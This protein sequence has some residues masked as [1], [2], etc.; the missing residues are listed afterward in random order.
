M[1]A[2]FGRLLLKS[3]LLKYIFCSVSQW[4][5]TS[6]L[7]TRLG[8]RCTITHLFRILCFLSISLALS[9]SSLY[10]AF[11]GHTHSFFGAAWSREPSNQLGFSLQCQGMYAFNDLLR[12]CM[13]HSKSN[14]H[15]LIRTFFWTC[16]RPASIDS[17][18]NRRSMP[19]SGILRTCWTLS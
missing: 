16:W 10:P 12:R 7:S 11:F 3:P 8:F 2:H 9:K 5:S 14:L 15:F 18:L 1:V 4:H 17:H 19:D 13:F 6:K